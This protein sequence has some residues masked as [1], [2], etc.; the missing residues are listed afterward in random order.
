MGVIKYVCERC[1]AIFN[2]GKFCGECGNPLTE[3]EMPL[4]NEPSWFLKL[5]SLSGIVPQPEPTP[6]NESKPNTSADDKGLVVLL[7]VCHHTVATVG[8]DGYT[9]TVLYRRD[10][11]TYEIHTYRKYEYMPQEEHYAYRT[12]K[13]VWDEVQKYLKKED[14][15]KFE[16]KNG[17]PVCGGEDVIKFPV[18]DRYVRLTSSNFDMKHTYIY[19]NLCAMLNKAIK[20]ENEIL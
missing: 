5:E 1:G 16:N 18:K 17:V 15:A 14:V 10:P 7:D 6:K 2:S 20:S 11:D 12:T 13:E 4:G 9:E 8:G 19:G 3:K